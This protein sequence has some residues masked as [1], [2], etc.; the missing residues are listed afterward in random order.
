MTRRLDGEYD[1]WDRE[2]GFEV[3]LFLS[4]HEANLADDV[5]VIS[6]HEEFYGIPWDGTP[7]PH[8]MERWEAAR[9]LPVER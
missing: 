3:D 2:A 7:K 4:I 5:D 9:E 6:L 1:N 8:L